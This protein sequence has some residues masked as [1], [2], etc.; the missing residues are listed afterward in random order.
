MIFGMM[1]WYS[2]TFG[3]QNGGVGDLTQYTDLP[4]VTAEVELH[5][6]NDWLDLYGIYYN[7]MY[8]VEGL[9]FAPV[10]DSFSVGAVATFGAV[11]IKFEHNC[12][13]PVSWHPEYALAGIWGGHNKLSIKINNRR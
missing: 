12:L 6:E 5:A 2:L 9:S 1:L 13:H 3:L 8:H 10:Q 7:G 11:S 4:P